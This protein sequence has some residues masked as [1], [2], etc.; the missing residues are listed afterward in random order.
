MP[1]LKCRAWADHDLEVRSCPFPFGDE[2]RGILHGVDDPNT[3]EARTG[4]TG[5]VWM[6]DTAYNETSLYNFAQP[7]PRKVAVK[8][9]NDYGD[10][11]MKVFTV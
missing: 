6:V 4:G 2:L 5:Q 11:V 3:G 7:E 8:A 9:I 1:L 10:E